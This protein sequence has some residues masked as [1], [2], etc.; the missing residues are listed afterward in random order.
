VNDPILKKQENMKKAEGTEK[1]AKKYV[2]KNQKRWQ[3]L[4]AH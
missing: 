3:H 2:W 4:A 1:K